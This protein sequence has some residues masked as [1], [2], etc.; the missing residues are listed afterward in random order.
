MTAQAPRSYRFRTPAQWGACLFD[1]VDREAFAA[2]ED[3]RPIAPYEQTAQLYP[4]RAAHAP[5]VTRAGEIL[6]HDDDG[7]LHRLTDCSDAPEV[8]PAP[9][10]P[11][12]FE[13]SRLRMDYGSSALRKLR[14]NDTRKTRLRACL[15]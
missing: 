1:R 3:I 6:W 2:H 12:H 14:W 7:C 11:V 5:V 9:Q 13:S 15:S 10:S 8:H 4:T